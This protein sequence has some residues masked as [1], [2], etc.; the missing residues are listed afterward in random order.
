[1]GVVGV[2][3]RVHKG[4]GVEGVADGGAVAGAV[5]RDGGAGVG[6]GL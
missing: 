6:V 2:D 1:M 3:V 5:D 4:K